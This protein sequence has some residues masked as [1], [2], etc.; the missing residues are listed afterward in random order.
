MITAT[1][2]VINARILHGFGVKF[3]A[4]LEIFNRLLA[5]V[6]FQLRDAPAVEC[7]CIGRVDINRFIKIINC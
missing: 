6:R 1:Q 5:I 2:A 3:K 4:L 7:L